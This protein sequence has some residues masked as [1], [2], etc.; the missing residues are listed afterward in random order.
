MTSIRRPSLGHL[1]GL[2]VEHLPLAQVMILGSCGWVLHQAP[3]GKSAS[4]SAYASASLSVSLMNKQIKIFK[5]KRPPL[6]HRTGK[7]EVCS[8][9]GESGG[10]WRVDVCFHCPRHHLQSLAVPSLII[11]TVPWPVRKGHFLSSFYFTSPHPTTDIFSGPI[12]QDWVPLLGHCPSNSRPGELTPASHPQVRVFEKP[13]HNQVQR[14]MEM[15]RYG[16]S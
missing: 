11:D 10:S 9:A 5:K 3:H 7:P 13:E 16:C 2:V 4:P 12:A 14:A 8:R 15:G 6:P 1:S